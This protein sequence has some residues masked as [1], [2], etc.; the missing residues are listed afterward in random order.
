[1]DNQIYNYLKKLGLDIP[2]M[3]QAY[4]EMEY[5][6]DDV[7]MKNI[8]I[9]IK[10][11]VPQ[12]RILYYIFYKTEFLF[13]KTKVFEETVNEFITPH[14]DEKLRN[15]IESL[16]IDIDFVWQVW[17]E[18]E[19][20]SGEDVLEK[21]NFLLNVGVSENTI[22]II[23]I[24]NPYFLGYSLSY[25]EEKIHNLEGDFDEVLMNNPYLL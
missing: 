10:K 5:F 6:T 22:A 1:M 12:E 4:P 2:F 7:A 8:E 21:I 24:Q 20:V 25:L 15:F 23:V 13:E 11:N 19:Q 9:L 16:G 3:L 17:P 14:I 18:I